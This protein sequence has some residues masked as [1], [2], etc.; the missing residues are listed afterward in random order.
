M[1][2]PMLF[3]GTVRSNILL[4]LD[5]ET[6][7][8][9]AQTDDYKFAISILENDLASFDALDLTETFTPE[10]RDSAIIQHKIAL[11]RAVY[12]SSISVIGID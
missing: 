4:D 1:E 9:T 12:H 7:A 2:A 11:A 8:K 3:P 6:A 5:P 10:I